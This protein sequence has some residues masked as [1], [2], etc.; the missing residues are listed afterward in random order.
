MVILGIDHLGLKTKNKLLPF[1]IKQK[2]RTQINPRFFFWILPKG[3]IKKVLVILNFSNR[4]PLLE[5]PI[6]FDISKV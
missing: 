1:L 4:T 2:T 3:M 6:T 5:N